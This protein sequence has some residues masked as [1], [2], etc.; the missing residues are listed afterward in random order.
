L[1]DAPPPP[2]PWSNGCPDQRWDTIVIG[3]G[4]GGMVAA[5]L[6]ARTGTRV[7]VLEAHSTPGGFTHS[8]RRHGYEFDVGLHA[9]GE[10]GKTHDVGR[11]LDYLTAGQLE[12]APIGPIYD[13]FDFP[14]GLH[15]DFPDDPDEFRAALGRA[16]P[17]EQPAIDSYLGLV[18]EARGHMRDYL[19]ARSLPLGLA[20]VVDRL[21]W[22][23]AHRTF[24]RTTADVLRS[25]GASP[26][27]GRVLTAQWGYYATPPARSSFGIHSIVVRHYLGG[28]YYPVGG[29]GRIAP[30][31]LAPVAAAGGWTRTGATVEQ[32]LIERG[33]AV[34]VRLVGGEEIRARRVISAVG[35]GATV[36]RLLPSEQQQARWAQQ[37]R[38][39]E[40]SPAHCALYLGFKGDIAAA[41]A[42]ASGQWFYDSWDTDLDGWDVGD[43]QRLGP[44]PMIYCSFASLK[45]PAHQPG[46]EQR[47]TG[48][49]LALTP[50]RHFAAW[51]SL[52]WR[53]RGA[54]YEQLKASLRRQLLAEL[55][56]RMPRL[57]P[58][59]DFAELS[60]PLSTD[61]FCHPVEGAMYGLRATPAR[62]SCPWLRPRSPIAGL[63]FAGAD[64]ASPGVVGSLIGGVLAA[65]AVAPV[66]TLAQV[67]H[68]R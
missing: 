29:A 59:I 51:Q 48:Q 19:L 23:R 68:L 57:G 58:L 49:V 27:L 5:A 54:D 31:L 1:N 39:L 47:H 66:G 55:L 4:I 7:L 30:A 60:T 50:W 12:W 64:A 40:P 21:V 20:P 14:G 36:R 9:V 65:L 62:Y 2:R 6:L 61:T 17:G 34:G 52:P 38:Q 3:S 33:R 45:D 16:F 35:I 41:G 8:F 67:R 37:V 56:R 46:P 43:P 24:A 22:R 32:L 18:R 11:L 44:P 26:R 15:L 63:Y 13:G 42:R 28:A 53:K 25:V 10:A